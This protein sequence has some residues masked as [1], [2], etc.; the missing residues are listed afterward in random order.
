MDRRTLI[1]A[2]A[3]SSLFSSCS[4]ESTVVGNVLNPGDVVD[5]RN[6]YGK[7][8]IEYV[9]PTIRRF[10]WGNSVIEIKLDARGE[11]FNGKQGLLPFERI[12]ST[13]DQ[14]IYEEFVMNFEKM[15]QLDSFLWAEDKTMDWVYTNSGLVGG[16]GPADGSHKSY[17]QVM[18]FLINNQKP[19]SISGSR[20]DNILIH[21]AGKLGTSRN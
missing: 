11:P 10:S 4:Q 3:S 21:S 2:I 14:I 9:S 5:I 15:S 13:S 17:V 6:R 16:L 20:P 18:Q 1:A 7:I 8:S 19:L 12:F